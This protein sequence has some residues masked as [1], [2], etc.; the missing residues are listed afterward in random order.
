MR[1]GAVQFFEKP[2]REDDL[3]RAIDEAIEVDQQQRQ[4]RVHQ[5][6]V[7]RYLATLSEK[8]QFVLA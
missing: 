2:C 5:E 8:E 6:E 1:A 3:W 7:E 4:R